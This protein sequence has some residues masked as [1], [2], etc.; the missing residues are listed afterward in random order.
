MA[1]H[2]SNKA[3][4]TGWRTAKAESGAV[5]SPGLLLGLRDCSSPDSI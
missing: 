5:V 2:T 4:C 3:V 1:R